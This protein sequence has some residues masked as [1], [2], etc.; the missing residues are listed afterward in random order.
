[1]K[2]ATAKATSNNSL[3]RWNDTLNPG[4]RAQ[5]NRPDTNIS[6]SPARLDMVAYTFSYH[7][8]GGCALA[9]DPFWGNSH[10]RETLLKY[11]F[12]EFLK[13]SSYLGKGELKISISQTILY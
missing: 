2:Q 6:L 9:K 3:Q 10:V 13:L 8:N 7:M 4:K 11:R 12:E 1:M 5:L